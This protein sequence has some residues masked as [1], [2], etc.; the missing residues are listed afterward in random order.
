VV[1][2]SVS[3]KAEP[4]RER[5]RRNLQEALHFLELKI[6]V[7]DGAMEVY[8]EYVGPGYAVPTPAMREAVELVARTE[9]IL[10]DPV[11]TGKAMAGLIDLVRRGAFRPEQNV[12]FLHT[13]GVPALFADTQSPAFYPETSA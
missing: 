6:P 13:G 12:V 10:L 5:I 1:G 2:I 8:D 4:L 9:G 3:G 7:H 11:Y